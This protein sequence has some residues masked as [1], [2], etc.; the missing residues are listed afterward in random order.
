MSQVTSNTPNL[1]REYDTPAITNQ[2]LDG[3]TA[4]M[5]FDSLIHL[6]WPRG[7]E[8]L[9]LFDPEKFKIVWIMVLNHQVFVLTTD[10]TARE[11]DE[12]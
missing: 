4:L 11:L 1:T 9:F 6:V 3:S 10:L 5:D 2:L 8:V 7:M 12:P